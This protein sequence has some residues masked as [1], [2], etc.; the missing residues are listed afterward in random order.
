MCLYGG[1]EHRSTTPFSFSAQSDTHVPHLALTQQVRKHC[2]YMNQS[3]PLSR[4]WRKSPGA[5]L[6]D[7]NTHPRL[8]TQLRIHT[9]THTHTIQLE[10]TRYMPG[11]TLFIS[12][13]SLP[14]LWW[15]C[16]LHF[17]EEDTK[18]LRGREP[19]SK[20]IHVSRGARKPAQKCLNPEPVFICC[21]PLPPGHWMGSGSP[22]SGLGLTLV[23]P[24]LSVSVAT[25]AA[26]ETEEG[27]E[28]RP[29]PSR[30][31]RRG[32]GIPRHAL[33]ASVTF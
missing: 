23:R 10:S 20:S 26:S 31:L 6:S 22:S 7:E 21:C 14:I 17:T 12:H 8:H 1:A 33:R 16:H 27:R 30:S 9:C 15:H 32:P 2:S 24:R 29:W 19:C 18:A 5:H 13:L 3:R 28:C 11:T 25:L 4:G